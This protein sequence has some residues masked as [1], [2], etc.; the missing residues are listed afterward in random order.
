MKCSVRRQ[1]RVLDQI[2]KLLWSPSKIAP[3]TNMMAA[4][5]ERGGTFPGIAWK[6]YVQYSFSSHSATSLFWQQEH[7]FGK[8]FHETQEKMTSPSLSPRKYRKTWPRPE[9]SIFFLINGWFRKGHMTQA[10]PTRLFQEPGMTFF[11]VLW[12]TRICNP[13]II[14]V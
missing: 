13:R 10:G 4:K 9:Q 8:P 1:G 7:F 2:R 14:L 11:V 6:S 3:W 5:M 12:D